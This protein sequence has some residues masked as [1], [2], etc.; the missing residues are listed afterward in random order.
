MYSSVLY[1]SE[2][3]FF[4]FSDISIRIEGVFRL[5]FTLFQI[6]GYFMLSK[7]KMT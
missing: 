5:K 1:F 7:K 2:G 4:V 6:K 3:A